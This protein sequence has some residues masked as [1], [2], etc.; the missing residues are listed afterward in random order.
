VDE[1]A[2]IKQY[3]RVYHMAHM[4]NWDNIVRFGLLSTT[5]LLDTFQIKGAQRTR[6]ESS[7]RRES[8]TIEHAEFGR[9][10]IRDQRPMSDATVLEAVTD[11]TPAEWYAFLNA[12]V[13]F[14]LT[15]VRLAI[16]NKARLYRDEE[17]LVF[18]VDTRSLVNAY[19][20]AILLSPINSGNT[21]PYKHKRSRE[22][23]RPIRSF[24]PRRTGDDAVVELTVEGGVPDIL[25]H[26]IAVDRW[27]NG[28]PVGIFLPWRRLTR[29]RIR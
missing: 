24:H 15:P 7:H 13:F 5:A 11:C 19:Y 16:M 17:Q 12:R 10:T 6:I 3:P 22:I 1:Q 28:E 8:I 2:F 23:F 9:A 4:D 26:T 27:K 14:W 18:T 25:E 29:G 20:S 21:V